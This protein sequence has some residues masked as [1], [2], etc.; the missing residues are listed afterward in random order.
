MAV[1]FNVSADAKYARRMS[2]STR[3]AYVCK[4]PQFAPDHQLQ[5]GSG[6]FLNWLRMRVAGFP[7]DYPTDPPPYFP[8][9]CDRKGLLKLDQRN[10]AS[11]KFQEYRSR[12]LPY[13][14]EK[15][16]KVRSYSFYTVRSLVSILFAMY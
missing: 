5:L 1:E 8:L 10:G 3:K 13:A 11:R 2:P 12:R 16:H 6:N 7:A 15:G 9:V 4:G 14:V